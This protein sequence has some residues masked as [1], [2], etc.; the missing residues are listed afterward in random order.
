[1]KTC[2]FPS[3]IATYSGNDWPH[4]I[5]LRTQPGTRLK[6]DS[7]EFSI[8]SKT[9]SCWTFALPRSGRPREIVPA[10]NSLIHKLLPS[11]KVK[12]RGRAVALR[13]APHSHLRA[14]PIDKKRNESVEAG[15]RIWL[16]Q[17]VSARARRLPQAMP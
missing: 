16:A 1:M 12:R 7:S 8:T 2:P 4:A 9:E 5:A 14:N 15:I 13:A 10:S 6:V 17:D 3:G 11:S